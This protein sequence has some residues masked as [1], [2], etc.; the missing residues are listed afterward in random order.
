MES[1]FR[2]NIQT[3]VQTDGFIITLGVGFTRPLLER[4]EHDRQGIRRA[5]YVRHMLEEY[6]QMKDQQQVPPTTTTAATPT[7]QEPPRRPKKR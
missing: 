7:L 4:I 5:K 6:Y 2:K 1:K 3:D